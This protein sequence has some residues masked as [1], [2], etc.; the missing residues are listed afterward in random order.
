MTKTKE[1]VPNKT[2]VAPDGE[3]KKKLEYNPKN[4]LLF[5]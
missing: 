2:I 5:Q 3:S 4:A 1:P